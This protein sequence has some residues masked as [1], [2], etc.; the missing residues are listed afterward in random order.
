MPPRR[1]ATGQ[2]NLRAPSAVSAVVWRNM[3]EL[4]ARFTIVTALL[5]AASYPALCQVTSTPL[6][7]RAASGTDARFSLL[8]AEAT[9]IDLVHRFPVNAPFDL[10]TD[11]YSGSGV[12]VGDVDADGL[13]DIFLTNYD[14]GNRLYKNLGNWKFR[15]TTAAAGVGGEGRWSAGATFADVDDD[16]DL[17]LFV[18]VYDAPN[19]LYVNDGKGVFND[20]AKSLSVDY[21]GA[22]VM[23]AFADYD[24]DGDLDGYLVTHRMQKGGH[25]PPRSS[26]DAF[27]RGII[28]ADRKTRTATVTPKF[29]DLFAIMD[30]GEDR[31]ELIT[32]GQQDI[33]YRNDGGK[34]TGVSKPAGI[35]GRGIGLAATWWD[36]N[37][38]SW[39]DLYVSNDYK[40]ADRLYR[41]NKNGTFTDVIRDT[42]PH[43][44]WLSMGSDLADVNNDGRMDFL[45]TDMAGSNH[46]RQKMGMGDMSKDRWF[47]IRS[48]PQQYMRNAL[49][50]NT[51]T[52]RLMEVAYLAGV[53]RSDW[54]WSPKFGDLDNDGRVD[55]FMT[56]GMSRNFMDSDLAKSFKG[57]RSEG[58]KTTPVLRQRNLAFRNAGDLKFDD[59]SKAW[60]LDQEAASYGAALTDLDRDGDLDLVHTNFDDPVSVWRNDAASGNGLLIRLE[61]TKSNRWG[62]GAKLTLIAGGITQT[63]YL[64]LSRGFM[65][66]NEPLVHFGIGSATA[67]DEFKIEWPSGAVQQLTGLK[68]N[69]LHSIREPSEKVIPAAKI[70]APWFK[71]PKTISGMRHRERPHD[72]YASQPLLPAKQ[73]Q[74][75]PCLATD[76]KFVFLGGAA[77]QPGMLMR[78]AARSKAVT[79]PFKSHARSEDMAAE[80]FDADGDGDSDLFV[81]SG[82]VECQPGASQLVDRL[83]LQE[84]KGTFTLAGA[85]T[86]PDLR[87]AGGAV[88]SADYDK[89]GDIDVFVGGRSIPGEFPRGAESYLLINDGGKFT[90]GKTDFDGLGIVTDAQWGDADGDAWAD[91][92]VSREWESV[93]LFLNQ[94]G[95]LTTTSTSGLDIHTG[96]WNTLALADLDGD[97][98]PDIAAGNYGLNTKYHASTKFPALLFYGDFDGSG[99][100]NIVEAENEGN[101]L[102]PARGKSCSTGAMPGIQ[103]SFPR[104]ASLQW[105]R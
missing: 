75:G 83:Y 57:W 6:G 62:I 28:V 44:P 98:D 26:K 48:D 63:R 87:V 31:I 8:Q 104:S 74:L 58:W 24:R 47:L 59:A 40:G 76:G 65:S 69:Q 94:N 34:F 84:A 82:G 52:S 33:L 27:A 92:F 1:T 97:G 20:R 79:A 54:T 39:P 21:A 56:N 50:L 7:K 10:M 61:G 93:V 25:H 99:K 42:V 32:A 90:E 17:D 41:N 38:D 72:D 37:E 64:T 45:A 73:S 67:A 95:I 71:M 36:Y 85:G 35:G 16:G 102:Y 4:A 88:A 101:I 105:H 78:V 86:L 46:F 2:P 11:Q 18:C 66:A 43:T 55:L 70:P 14:H 15:D 29:E 9:G 23:M 51:G 30:K 89:D 13:P 22:S 96:W 103:K 49:L 91:L 100:F 5:T 53:A 3:P 68:P 60:G 81:V 77:G 80:F 12:C 19:L